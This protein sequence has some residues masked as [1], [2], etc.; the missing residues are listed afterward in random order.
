MYATRS[1][2][3]YFL[4]PQPRAL[5]CIRINIVCAVSFGSSRLIFKELVRQAV[6][7]ILCCQLGRYSSSAS[8]SILATI[9]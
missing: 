2:I 7:G 5:C 6:T 1:W 4:L 8:Q 3:F 9:E